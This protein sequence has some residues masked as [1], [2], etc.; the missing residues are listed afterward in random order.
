MSRPVNNEHDTVVA[1]GEPSGHPAAHIREPYQAVMRAVE[2]Y[3]RDKPSPHL[4]R[5]AARRLN[6]DIGQLAGHIAHE[7]SARVIDTDR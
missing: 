1:G 6:S 3:L 4:V 5:E 2:T 7:L